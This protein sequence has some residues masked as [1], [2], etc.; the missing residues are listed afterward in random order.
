MHD[1]LAC[2]H[3]RLRHLRIGVEALHTSALPALLEFFVVE[4]LCAQMLIVL[5]VLHLF[6]IRLRHLRIGVE[7]LHTFALAAL[8]SGRLVLALRAHVSIVTN[9]SSF[10]DCRPYFVWI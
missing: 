9:V 6:H 8:L 2:F 7:A 5:H 10:R 4:A 1:V 3:L